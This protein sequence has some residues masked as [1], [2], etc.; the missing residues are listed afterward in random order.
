MDTKVTDPMIPS[1]YKITSHNDETI[2]TFTVEL[3]PVDNT[4]TFEFLP[5]QFCMLHAFGIGESAISISGDPKVKNIITHTIKQV[6]SVTKIL[7]ALNF[8]ST[9]G[10]RGPFGKAWPVKE[11]VGKNVVIVAGGIGLAPLRP[12][13]YHIQANR[14]QYKKVWLFYGARTPKDVIY[15]DEI[16]KWRKRGDIDINLTVDKGGLLWR[17]GVGTVTALMEKNQIEVNNTIAL[18]CGPEIMIHFSVLSLEKMGFSKEAIY[19]SMERN[20][21]CGLGYCGHCMC[22]SKFICKDG[23][24]LKYSEAEQLLKVREL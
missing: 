5:G 21:Q 24:V 22:G 10:V 13:I 4:Q 16:S 1:L 2:D 23:P 15:E 19:V 7:E 8:G 17:G 12:M 18:V 6:G 20:M 3:Q 11:T 14:E 9:I